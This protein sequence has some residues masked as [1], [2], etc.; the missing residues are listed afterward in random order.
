MK[1]EEADLFDVGDPFEYWAQQACKLSGKIQISPSFVNE[2]IA[3]IKGAFG[4]KWLRN[5]F[6][7]KMR[8]SPVIAMPKHRI[9][10]NLSTPGESQIIEIYELAIYIKRLVNVKNLDKVLKMMKTQYAEGL[11]QLAWGYRFLRL[12]AKN[13]EFEPK[14]K[15]GKLGDIFFELEGNQ[16]MVE[17]Y[18]PRDKDKKDSSLELHHCIGHIFAAIDSVNKVLRVFI[19]LKK[20]I[21]H[22]ERKE[23]QRMVI[24]AIKRPT[25]YK[26]LDVE[27]KFAKVTIDD[28]SNMK[29][30]NDFPPF[31]GPMNLFGEADWGIR[32]QKVPRDRNVIQQIREGSYEHKE[33]HSRIFVKKP[34]SEKE[35]IPIKE[36]IKK[37]TR[38][39]ENK[40]AQT[41]R[42]GSNVR[43]IVVAQ[44]TE[45]RE[46]AGKKDIDSQY[47]CQQIQ[48][49]IVPKHSNV[50]ALFLCARTWTTKMRHKYMG[51]ILLGREK[52]VISNTLLNKLIDIESKAEWLNDWR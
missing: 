24:S 3:I 20:S 4:E 47:I 32:Q 9:I 11:M 16:Y 33:I 50:S 13:L 8:N 48:Q 29:Q 45:G 44:V 34:K 22:R 7:E 18:M 15:S 36:K 51:S 52:D 38:K 28:I 23:I 30:D 5:S 6:D 40:L 42:P 19:A 27:N 1:K 43:R 25:Q 37:L 12:E 49:K 35:D 26:H 21:C 31:P 39:I 17:C 2:A 46:A 14:A 41:K 10:R